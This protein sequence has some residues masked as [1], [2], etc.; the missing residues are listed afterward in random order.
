M[1]RNPE[2]TSLSKYLTNGKFVSAVILLAGVLGCAAIPLFSNPFTLVYPPLTSLAA[3]V[4]YFVP[5][6]LDRPAPD[7]SFTPSPQIL[8]TLYLTTVAI[9]V[10]A[11]SASSSRSA[12]VLAGTVC[13]YAI[14]LVSFISGHE[15]AALVLLF[16]TAIIHRATMVG[17]SVLILGNDAFLHNQLALDVAER[18]SRAPLRDGGKHYFGV[19]GY[20]IFV[21][22]VK[23]VSGGAI[24]SVT[25]ASITSMYA[26][27]GGAAVYSIGRLVHSRQSA[28]FGAY[29]FLVS[30][31]ALGWS[32]R[33]SPTALGVILFSVVL[34]A[35]LL[36]F[37][38][39]DSR[40]RFLA[41]VGVVAVAIA[42][43][44]SAFL[45]VATLIGLGVIMFLLSWNIRSV[46][47][48]AF[49]VAVV[50]TTWAYATYTVP[51]LE[52][53][54]T[55]LAWSATLLGS[56]LL[57]GGIRTVESAPT[58]LVLSGADSLTVIHTVGGAILV[59]LAIC[60][61]LWKLQY[62]PEDYRTHTA[63]ALSTA[64]GLILGVAFIGPVAGI[65][66]LQPMR[67]F[68]FIF[69]LLT[70]VAGIAV[71]VILRQGRHEGV[72]RGWVVAGLLLLTMLM[73]G[74]FIGA[75]DDPIFDSAP[76]A[77]RYLVTEQENEAYKFASAKI[78]GVVYSDHLASVVISR[79]YGS[80]SKRLTVEYPSRSVGAT[81]GDTLFL[82]PYLFERHAGV[83]ALVADNRYFAFYPPAQTSICRYSG[84]VYSSGNG[85]ELV[86]YSELC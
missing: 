86:R 1:Y 44:I 6:R 58:D 76:G 33:P 9:L 84:T 46:L 37:K 55:F 77:Q 49:S 30:D 67:F 61:L 18:G 16:L 10:A 31:Y 75:I 19:P 68:Q 13:L 56:R 66:F 26:V 32:V 81:A 29:L 22:L 41:L 60:A 24:K 59:A 78:E 79:H 70:P 2:P 85:N 25:F 36:D 43:H 23:L 14:T 74:T 20:H 54:T 62:R 53:E 34:A 73:G 21:A 72:A 4:G 82:R 12:L 27:V 69:V 80:E 38:R 39:Q 71:A 11:F 50:L 35:T 57:T 15:R 3:I 40:Y 5:H 51:A 45:T 52:G 63:L 48:S 8:L 42:H 83:W 7:W 47:L 64:G 28:F 17:S 65:R